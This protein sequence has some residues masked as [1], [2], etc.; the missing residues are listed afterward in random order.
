MM[1]WQLSWRCGLTRTQI[2]QAAEDGFGPLTSSCWTP[3]AFTW[4]HG[5]A[6]AS[7]DWVFSPA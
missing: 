6:Y 5:A 1:T 2:E 7:V 3:Y 4:G